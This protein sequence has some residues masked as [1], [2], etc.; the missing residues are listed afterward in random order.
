M[1]TFLVL[2]PPGAA[3]GDEKA[4]IIRDR[5][6]WIALFLPV[7]WLL[8]HRAWLAAALAFAVQ[9]LGSAVADHP[10]FGLAG[11]GICLATNL[12]VAL[13]GPSMVV[14]G[15]TRRGWTVDAVITADDRA[16]A[17]EIYYMQTPAG[18]AEPRES[19]LLPASE[20]SPR[21]HA[22]MLGLVGFKE[23]R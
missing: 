2:I 1:A 10:L 17:E 4:R 18:E 6:S 8:W 7:L 23:G 19:V 13:E 16:T 14:A 9:S 20:T 15:L 5:F 22:P 11:L 21:R 12:L 3:S